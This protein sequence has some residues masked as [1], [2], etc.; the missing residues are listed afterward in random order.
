[1]APEI[2][3]VKLDPS[4]TVASVK[5]RLSDLRGKRVLLLLSPSGTLFKRKLDLILLQREAYRRAIQLALVSR[6]A[7]II[8]DARE[9]NISCFDSVKASEKSRWKRGRQKVFLPRQH[10]PSKPQPPDELRSI[11]SRALG[12]NRQHSRRRIYL[13]RLFVLALLSLVTLAALYV[14]VPGATVEVSLR[15]ES[16]NAAVTIIADTAA[17]G[18]DPDKGIIP[19]QI[20][21]ATV[22]TTAT[23]PTTGLRDLDEVPARGTV[24]FTNLTDRPLTV[25]ANTILSSSAAAPL[26]FRTVVDVFLPAGAAS[27]GECAIRG[28]GT[29]QR[30]GR[31]YSGRTDQPGGGTPGGKRNGNK[32]SA[33]PRRRD[34]QGQYRFGL[35]TKTGC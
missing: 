10:Q 28:H 25:P 16:I 8:A 17:A 5:L 18:V 34:A 11:A 2:V 26:L 22:E 6:E 33:S 27:D 24:S 20:A 12:R 1:M 4:D 23:V 29:I 32:S 15:A 21:R 35:P 9:L 13:E 14:V 30:R 19:A 3:E 31:Q 7:D